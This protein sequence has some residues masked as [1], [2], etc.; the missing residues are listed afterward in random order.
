MCRKCMRCLY[1]TYYGFIKIKRIQA[2]LAVRSSGHDYIAI[3]IH[4]CQKNKPFIIVGMLADDIDA[5]RGTD[6]KRLFTKLLYMVRLYLLYDLIHFFFVY[7][8]HQKVVAAARQQPQ[9]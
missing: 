8:V 6:Y 7:S 9:A 3:F 2:Y 5:A 4:G 1:S